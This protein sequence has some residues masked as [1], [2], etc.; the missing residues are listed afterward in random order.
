M[1]RMAKSRMVIA[2]AVAL[3]AI[4]SVQP[5]AASVKVRADFDKAFKFGEMR[6]WQ[7]APDPGQVILARTQGEDKDAVRRRAEP[8]IR[9]VVA[10]EMPRRGL[11]LAADAPDLTLAYYLAMTVGASAQSMGQFL[12]TNWGLPLFAPSTQSLE[13]VERGAL[14]LD[15]SSQGRVVW[16]GIGEA[17]FTMDLDAKKR[18]ALLRD[19]VK[20]V[21]ERFPP[22]QKT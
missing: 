11:T 17:G 6:T 8:V 12:P 15:L 3:A 21:L 4:W 13:A 16:R 20:K 14:V 1:E 7:W 9:E 18:E 22:K 19:A 5:D 10:A 2:I